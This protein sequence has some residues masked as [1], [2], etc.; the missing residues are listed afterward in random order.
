MDVS[1]F[2]QRRFI[3]VSRWGGQRHR[4]SRVQL[5][6]FSVVPASTV[7]WGNPPIQSQQIF[8]YFESLAFIGQF[9]LDSERKHGGGDRGF[10]VSKTTR[11]IQVICYVPQTTHRPGR[12]ILIIRF[13]SCR[14]RL[15]LSSTYQSWDL[16]RCFNHHGRDDV[17]EEEA[18]GIGW[19]EKC[20][21]VLFWFLSFV[22]NQCSPTTLS[23]PC[24]SR[25]SS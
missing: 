17:S 13:S 16:C 1:T 21:W 23:V 14:D 3:I 18:Q 15:F 24:F 12:L 22:K 20:Y 8:R 11:K 7:V 4:H 6:E 10:Y 19:G 5:L 25:P 2:N 9:T